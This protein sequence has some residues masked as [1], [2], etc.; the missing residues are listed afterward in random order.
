MQWINSLKLKPKLM[1]TFGVVLF[2]MLLQ[3][4][5]AYRGLH[6]L[7]NVTTDLA[8]KRTPSLRTTGELSGMVSEYRNASY[9]SLVRAS[10]DVKAD[11]KTRATELRM[12]IDTTIGTSLSDPHDGRW[13][14]I[15]L[16]LISPPLF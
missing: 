15:G 1:L 2:V 14:S 4:I 10:D 13:L 16:R 12:Q 7:N 9:Q 3:G 11:A 6:S 8:E 5:V